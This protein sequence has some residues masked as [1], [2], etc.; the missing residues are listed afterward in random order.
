MC[1]CCLNHNVFF[2]SQV[3][4][5]KKKPAVDRLCVGI[6]PGEVR[7]MQRLPVCNLETSY[8]I[9]QLLEDQQ[10]YLY[11]FFFSALVCLE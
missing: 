9:S 4:D 2:A 11:P 10:F 8:Y 3:Y 6:P 1:K 5:R 7:H